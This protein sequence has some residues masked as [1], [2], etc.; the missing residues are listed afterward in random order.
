MRNMPSAKLAQLQDE[1]VTVEKEIA[2]LRAIDCGT[3]EALRADVDS[4][5]AERAARADEIAKLCQ[6]EHELD[7][8]VAGLRSV[9]SDSDSRRV[10]EAARK[11]P[12]IHVR[13]GSVQGFESADIA[14]VA[15]QFLRGLARGEVR[16]MG[17]Y[18]ADQGQE[19]TAPT[20]LYGSIINVMTRQSVGL[21]VASVFNTIAKKLTLPKV[22]EGSAAFYAEMGEATPADLNTSGVDVTLYGLRKA[23]AVSNDLIEDSVVDIASLFATNTGNAFASKVDYAWLQG[24]ATAGIDGLVGEVTNEVAVASASATTAAKLADMVGMIDPL[25]SNTAWVVS[26]AGFGALLAAHAG[27]SSVML[28][29]AMAPT[30]Y[31][32]PVYVTNGLPSGTL[33]LYGDFSFA[34]AVAV[35]AS[36]L[37]VQ[38]LRELQAMNDRT[39]FVAK[40]R[41]GIAN[42]A[43]EFVAK[44]II[45]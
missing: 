35:K 25:A 38:A 36:G 45:D 20:E 13:A 44:L 1:S 42:H 19:L 31:G 26:P 39:V 37:Q 12:A 17:E 10:V 22:S 27:T 6:R 11:A 28:S 18:N 3:D 8:K 32:R 33:A 2:E 7:A 16:A 29:D 15:G 5:L 41:V 21:R 23:T 24:D 43:P 34:T 9:R 14:A 30:V 4:R 40:Q